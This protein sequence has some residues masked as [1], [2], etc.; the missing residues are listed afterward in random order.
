[1]EISKFFKSFFLLFFSFAFLALANIFHSKIKKP[2]IFISKQNSS[3]NL[4]F[5]FLQ[6]ANMGHKRFI[7]SLLW[8]ATILESD[9]DHYKRKDLNSWMFLRFKTI[10]LLEPKFY[11]V[12]SFGAQYL[13]IIKDDLE[14]ATFLYERGLHFYPED[15]AI[16]RDSA[17]HFH[18]EVQDF[19]KS[20]PILRTLSKNP[21]TSAIM[22]STLARL[23][24]DAGN[25][26][27]AYEMLKTKLANI[28]PS[29]ILYNVVR[30]HLYSIKA[31]KD[32]NCLNSKKNEG[33]CSL[34]DEYGE[35]YVWKNGSYASKTAWKPY[36]LNRR[37][38]N[39]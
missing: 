10:T 36:S 16:L 14:G 3:I 17:F 9:I 13:S 20:L 24:K 12:Y 22:I 18:F 35:K 23:E 6:A 37:I 1:M 25:T 5:K 30:E 28:P 11:Q 21:K 15:Y 34:V 2:D 31:E 29:S 39:N 19:S 4:N 33:N 7:S 26:D 8:I 27:S 32:L 38:K